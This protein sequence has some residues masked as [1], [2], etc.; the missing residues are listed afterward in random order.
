MIRSNITAS[1][2]ETTHFMQSEQSQRADQLQF[3]Y[4]GSP[5]ESLALESCSRETKSYVVFPIS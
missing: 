5:D 4:R 2:Q 1:L 3:I